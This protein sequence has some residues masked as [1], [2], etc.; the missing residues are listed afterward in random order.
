MFVLLSNSS[1][2]NNANTEMVTSFA[3]FTSCA[4][5]A[6]DSEALTFC[7]FKT[8]TNKQC[9]NM[10]LKAWVYHIF[11]LN[12][13]L[14]SNHSWPREVMESPSLETLRPQL[15]MGLSHLNWLDLLWQ[16]VVPHDIQM[17]FPPQIICDSVKQVPLKCLNKQNNSWLLKDVAAFCCF[18][19]R[20]VDSRGTAAAG[21][22]WNCIV[23]FLF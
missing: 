11:W 14:G 5:T 13:G 1:G 8:K 21:L 4:L 17:S 20:P 3:S 19:Q 6:P 9:F 22:R 10:D 23:H 2:L 16:E 15:D 18:V 7:L 12:V